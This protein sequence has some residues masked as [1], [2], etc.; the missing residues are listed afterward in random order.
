MSADDF[1]HRLARLL[2]RSLM[3]LTDEGIGPDGPDEDTDEATIDE[4]VAL[5]R[6][7]LDEHELWDAGLIDDH[8]G[9]E[10]CAYRTRSN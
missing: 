4:A 5:V 10:R 9:C 6:D 1:A 7:Q 8:A 2:V 3:A